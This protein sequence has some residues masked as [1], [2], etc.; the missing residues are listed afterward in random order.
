MSD[1]SAE[2]LQREN[3]EL[4]MQLGEAKETLDAIRNGEIDAL[5]VNDQ[6]GLSLY[7]LK[8]ADRSYR[9]F[10]EQMTE[11]AVTLNHTR[12]LSFI[13]ILNSQG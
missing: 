11:G 6:H 13:V 9:L 12:V 7:T 8:S 10:I 3:E 4:R 2:A 5:V 1:V